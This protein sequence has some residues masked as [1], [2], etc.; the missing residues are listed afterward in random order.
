MYSFDLLVTTGV[1]VAFLLLKQNKQTKKTFSK[2]PT[3]MAIK[4]LRFVKLD[5][6]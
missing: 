2:L 4:I 3:R 6:V 1:N 5:W